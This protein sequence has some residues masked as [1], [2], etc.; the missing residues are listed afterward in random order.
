[1]QN[2]PAVTDIQERTEVA[3][4]YLQMIRKQVMASASGMPL[5]M[6]LPVTMRSS[7]GCVFLPF[8]GANVAGEGTDSTKISVA[9]PPLFASGRSCPP[10]HAS[11]LLLGGACSLGQECML[12]LKKHKVL[13]LHLDGRVAN[14][15]G[16][17]SFG[18]NRGG[19]TCTS[20]HC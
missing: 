12:N 18:G 10:P 11:L 20:C 2:D 13:Q 4:G 8:E 7:S 16:P 15:H 14:E 19:G 9:V 1:M 5:P 17:Q 6:S 3:L